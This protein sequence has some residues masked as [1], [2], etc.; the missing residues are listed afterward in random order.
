MKLLDFD[1]DV[2]AYVEMEREH[3]EMGRP[4]VW[5]AGPRAKQQQQ[6]EEEAHGGHVTSAMEAREAM[7]S[8]AVADPKQGRSP[9]RPMDA[10]AA[11]L[12][13]RQTWGTRHDGAVGPSLQAA[14]GT[15]ACTRHG[16]IERSPGRPQGPRSRSAHR[17][18][19]RATCVY[20]RSDWPA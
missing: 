3:T 15:A 11:L 17:R 18:I 13:G 8:G 4:V 10:T 20:L 5:P 16:Y 7:T 1:F 2:G 19:R 9:R 6:G 12:L 14:R